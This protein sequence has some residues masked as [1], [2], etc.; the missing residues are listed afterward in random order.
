MRR[1]LIQL[2][3]LTFRN[4]W[5]MIKPYIC[6]LD[7][8]FLLLFRFIL[9]YRVLFQYF[10]FVVVVSAASLVFIFL[11]NPNVSCSKP[12]DFHQQ[13]FCI[14]KNVTSILYVAD[15]SVFIN[16]SSDFNV[17][18]PTILELRDKQNTIM[19]TTFCNI[20]TYKH[21]HTDNHPHRHAHTICT[22]ILRFSQNIFVK[23]V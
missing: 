2:K 16:F 10:D 22:D 15:A 21:T 20:F 11:N 3:T 5:E 6:H 14:K 1:T 4:K 12:I 13:N 7:A 18:N 19:M 17:K 23:G 8:D 9:L